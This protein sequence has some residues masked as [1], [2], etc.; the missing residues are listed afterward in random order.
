MNSLIRWGMGVSCAGLI[1]AVIHYLK[2][3]LK[4]EKVLA[5]AFTSFYILVCIS[6][7]IGKDKVDFSAWFP[8]ETQSDDLEQKASDLVR[9]A[10]IQSAD[11]ALQKEIQSVLNAKHYS[12]H[13]ILI[14]MNIDSEN[15]ILINEI[16][17]TG[18]PKA[19]MQ[20]VHDILNETLGLEV[21]VKDN[22]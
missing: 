7:L 11:H 1:T 3:G 10:Y 13:Q 19:Q 4:F 14:A 20:K 9:S 6:P 21:A 12:F 22:D 2:P 18:V 16:T 5:I 8:D 15:N 17:I